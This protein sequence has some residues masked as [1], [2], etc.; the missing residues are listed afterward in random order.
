MRDHQEN[1]VKQQAVR[2]YSVRYGHSESDVPGTMRMDATSDEGLIQRLHAFVPDGMRN[3]TWATVFD[4]L[5][6]TGHWATVKAY[7]G[8]SHD[9]KAAAGRKAVEAVLA[10]TPVA[11]AVESMQSEWLAEAQRSLD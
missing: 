7:C 11:E 1:S 5:P 10:G 4:R 2:S 3:G 8:A 6:A 9:Q